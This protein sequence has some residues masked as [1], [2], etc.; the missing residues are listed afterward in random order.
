MKHLKLLALLIL[1]ILS[2]KIELFAQTSYIPP[3]ESVQVKSDNS[4]RYKNVRYGSVPDSIDDAS[5]DRILDI[6]LPENPQKSKLAV[7]VFIHGGGFRNG[8]KSVA[9]IEELCSK[10]ASKGF[11][12]L[13]INYRLTL[14]YKT[15]PG[16]G[17]VNLSKG[18]PANKKFSEGMRI[19]LNNASEDTEM[20]F[21]WI[22]LQAEKYNFNS[23]SVAIGGSSAGAMTALNVAY[24]RKSKTLPVNAVVDLWGGMENAELIE[25]NAPPLLIYHGDS[26]RVVHVDFAYSLKKQMDKTGNK[27]T[28]LNIM[29]GQGHAQYD[30]ILKYKLDEIIAFLKNNAK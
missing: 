23:S 21:E 4:I 27:K 9:A 28:R 1:L 8:D 5:S 30:V 16:S 26:D 2:T 15:Y 14:K 3:T 18:L 17:S 22:K 25:K 13:S 20:L 12:V 7:F 10:I 6:Y 19:A 24:I 11:A 29:A